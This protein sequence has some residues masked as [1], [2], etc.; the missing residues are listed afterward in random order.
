M[1]E[2]ELHIALNSGRLSKTEIDALVKRLQ[3]H[4][5]LTKPL[6][7]EV[8]AQD[9][10]GDFNASWVF[11]H[12][13]R[14]RLDFILPHLEL[15]AT[16]LKNLSSESCIRPMAHTCEF[17]TLA[18][19]KQKK[20]AF[21]KNMTSEQLER[22]TVVCFDWLIGE[23][24]VASKVFSM[25]ALFYLGERFEWIYPELKMV[26]ENTIADGT[27]GYKNRAKKTIDKL[28]ALGY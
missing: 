10:L 24:K 28:S 11:D 3:E 13:M 14:K 19:F 23:H 25:S 16:A 20:P 8:F 27:V 26:L 1:T 4:P 17:L 12:L 18:Y 9:K 21:R 15:F 5:E 22:L 2:K 6:L 7:N